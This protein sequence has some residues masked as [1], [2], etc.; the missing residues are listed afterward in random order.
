MWRLRPWLGLDQVV[1]RLRFFN[2]TAVEVLPND[3]V[4]GE[5]RA[6]LSTALER[7]GLPA[8]E[9]T[10]PFLYLGLSGLLHAIVDVL[11]FWDLQ[12]LGLLERCYLAHRRALLDAVA[13]LG[14]CEM[15]AS[16]AC[17]AAEEPDAAWPEFRES[18]LGL[19]I[20]DGR[21]PLLAADRAVANSLSLSDPIA[22]WVVTG[23]N[24]S[25]K[26]TFLRMTGLTVHL[27]QIGSAVTAGRAV[28]SPVQLM[29]DLRIR[30]DLSREESYFL[31]EVRQ[32]R[33]MVRAAESGAAVF[34]I[35]DEPFRG[36]NSEERVAAASAVI[37]ALV[38]G[39]GI[40][41]VATHD[42]FLTRLADGERAANRHFRESL[43]GGQLVFDY[44]LHD[45]PAETR[46][47]LA[48]LEHEG[49][50][51]SLTKRARAFLEQFRQSPSNLDA[52]PVRSAGT[53][54]RSDSAE[55][56]LG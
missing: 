54:R 19:E 23:S 44:R 51:E 46:N 6:R 10:I 3:G 56:R 55:P 50:P 47:A 13:A 2:E 21:H 49:Y 24:M 48:V 33:R 40:F 25:G 22:M 34:G 5:Q 31:A 11:V 27:A 26:S 1:N 30:D 18:G 28:L 7:G 12:V 17:L 39:S 37:L 36:T 20:V 53:S 45:G 9:R 14:E 42:A 32:I 29:T 8:L 41:L 15:L 4:L 52:G 43:D 38:E 35:I 16:L